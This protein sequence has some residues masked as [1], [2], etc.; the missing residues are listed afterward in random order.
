MQHVSMNFFYNKESLVK[1]VLVVMFNKLLLKLWLF[2]VII[3]VSSTET[4]DLIICFRKFLILLRTK[5][6]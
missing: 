1:K 3:I 4:T 5:D 6:L 2:L